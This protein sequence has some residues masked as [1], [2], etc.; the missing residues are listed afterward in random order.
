MVEHYV[1][2]KLG[3]EPVEYDHPLL[4]PILK[5]TYSVIVYQEQAMQIAREL[6]GYTMSE[7]DELRKGIGK[8]K[9]EIISLHHQKFVDGCI[10]NNIKPEVAE[11]IWSQIETM[12]RYA[13][14][15][16]HSCAYSYLSYITAY[17]KANYPLQYMVC[18][19]NSVIDK[20]DK[21]VYYLQECIRM[22]LKILP[23]DINKSYGLFTIENNAIRYGLSAIKKVSKQLIE[24][25][26]IK[27]R[28]KKPFE[29]L[30]D[31]I[32][33]VNRS[34]LRK[35]VLINLIKAGACDNIETKSRL[36]MIRLVEDVYSILN[37][38]QQKLKKGKITEDDLKNIILN[39]EI[40]DTNNECNILNIEKEEEEVL[41]ITLY[42]YIS[43]ASKLCK[44]KAPNKI[45]DIYYSNN[46]IFIITGFI[47][48]VKDF[49]IKKGKYKGSKVYVFMLNDFDMSIK[50]VLYPS[51]G[52][53][54]IPQNNDIIAVKGQKNIN[55]NNIELIIKQLKKF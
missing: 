1:D 35:D 43:I 2:R 17:L 34:V 42:K 24:E 44:I 53:K 46:N 5:N 16:S 48:N 55:D 37:K 9:P 11:K 40:T 13:F 54:Y 47:N 12:G 31:L 30:K 29:S 10:K 22:G 33:R 15:L 52:I 8:K 49:I 4:K 25:Y 3:R 36:F 50:C 45:R 38:Q 14:N 26:I 18:V 28:N 23:P 7:A 41:G 32:L 39:Y 20:Q 6:A 27:E 51:L 21:L 19:L